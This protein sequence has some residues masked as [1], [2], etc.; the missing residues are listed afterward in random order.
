M[1]P[2]AKWEQLVWYGSMYLVG[3]V[4]VVWF[5]VPS[6]NSLKVGTV[7]VARFYELS[8]VGV[9][10]FHAMR[11]VPC[12]DLHHLGLPRLEH[13]MRSILATYIG[14]DVAEHMEV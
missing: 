1:V 3:T 6:G 4:S 5:H 11:I 10:W 9:E 14:R 8:G 7:S 13:V 2:C 12:D